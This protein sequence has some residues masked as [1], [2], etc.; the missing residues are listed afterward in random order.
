[1]ELTSILQ[2]Q[3]AEWQK[4]RTVQRVKQGLKIRLEMNAPYIGKH[5]VFFISLKCRG[6]LKA[7]EQCEALQMFG[8]RL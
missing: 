7:C 4:L 3:K 2:S 1:M 8:H 6:C 5:D